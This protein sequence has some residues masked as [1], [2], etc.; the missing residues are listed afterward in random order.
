VDFAYQPGAWHD[1]YATLATAYAALLGLF[2]VAIS[3]HPREVGEHPLL[4]TRARISLVGLAM[5]LIIALDCLIPQGTVVALGAELVVL[6]SL[7]AVV[8]SIN[9]MRLIR[10]L[11]PAPAGVWLRTIAALLMALFGICGGL[12]LLIGSGGGMLWNVAAN[13]LGLIIALL[14]V[15]R[16]VCARIGSVRESGGQ[17]SAPP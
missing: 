11:D 2:F 17:S 16:H 13:L 4:R 10:L 7:W 5:L 1:F 14:S 3:L 15:E 9:Q 12:T 8:L 6:W